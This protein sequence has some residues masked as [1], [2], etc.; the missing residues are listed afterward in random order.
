MTRNQQQNRH[1]S[2]RRGSTLV[3]VCILLGIIMVAIAFSVD[4]ARIQL[5]QLELQ[6]AADLSCRAGAESLSRGV[7]DPDDLALTDAA[8]RDEILMV[9]RLNTVNGNQVNLL[10]SDITF[11]RADVQATQIAFVPSSTGE[12]DNATDSVRVSPGISNY[13][14][15]FGKFVGRQNIDL[16]TQAA[17]MIA[18]RD[19]VVVLDRSTSMTSRDAGTVQVGDY[20]ANLLS[21][22]QQLWADDDPYHPSSPDFRGF[23]ADFYPGYPARDVLV[24][25]Q[26]TDVN[27]TR[28][29]ALRIAVQ[30]FVGEIEA[31]KGREQLGLSTYGFVANSPSEGQSVVGGSSYDIVNGLTPAEVSQ[32]VGTGITDD[33]FADFQ[34]PSQKY[35]SALEGEDNGYAAF[36]LNYLSMRWS[37]W[38]HIV[39]GIEEGTQILFGPGSRPLAT[40]VLILMTDG[41]HNQSGTPTTAATTAMAA[42]PDLLIYTVTFGAGADQATMQSIATIGNGTHSHATD[43]TQLVNVFRDLAQ[44]AGVT[45][46]E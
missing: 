46:I 43:V 25:I 24:D 26:G 35:A 45:L 4:F 44:N 16:E 7:G 10:S 2:K 3:V 9:G 27:L 14:I 29:Q 1:A 20:P 37:E 5:T 12:I 34:S 11:G 33:N 17:A 40:P 23:A 13:P 18:E 19:I 39:D 36:K 32:L 21:L 41:N 42:N 30:A 31:S 8:V 22:E 6:S 38:T 28:L 15:T